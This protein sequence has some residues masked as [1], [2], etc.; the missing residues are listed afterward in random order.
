M[1]RKFGAKR[2]VHDVRDRMYKG[3]RAP[4]VVP[5][6]IDLREFGGSE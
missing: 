3:A 2:D 6:K 4:F 1:I 5:Q